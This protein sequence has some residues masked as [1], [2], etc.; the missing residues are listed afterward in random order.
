MHNVAFRG[1]RLGA[2]AG[3]G[4]LENEDVEPAP[5][6]LLRFACPKG[7]EFEVPFA[8]DAELPRTWD[9]RRHGAESERVDAAQEQRKVKP[10][11]T[12]WDMLLER[13]S[14]ADLEALLDE[15]L[16]E[17]REQR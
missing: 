12:H 15:R 16:V 10:P 17:L 3:A 6:R 8:E 1:R 11:R 14:I 7:H 13:R 9:C 5:R 4:S 2:G